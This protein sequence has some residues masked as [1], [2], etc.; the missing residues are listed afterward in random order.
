[1]TNALVQTTSTEGGADLPAVAP[2]N[3]KSWELIEASRLCDRMK[4][5]LRRVAA[6]WPSREAA[7]AEGYATHQDLWRYARRYDLVDIRTK[8]IMDGNR[9]IAHLANELVEHR[10]VETP[11]A[12]S[13]RDLSIASGIAQD[14]LAKHE[15]WGQEE[16]ENDLGA[17][18]GAFAAKLAHAGGRLQARLTSP[19][20]AT[21]ELEISGPEQGHES[22]VIDVTPAGG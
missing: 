6:G 1:M 15:R 5:A 10:L 4:R 14:K 8:R 12:I 3:Q 9:R 22:E 7:E 11:D 20:G 16:V 18:I 13:T 21:A 2:E 17:T 19:E